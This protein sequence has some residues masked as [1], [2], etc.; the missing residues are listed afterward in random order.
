M[1][2]KAIQSDMPGADSISCDKHGA[3]L[4]MVL[5]HASRLYFEMLGSVDIWSN[6]GAECPE[7]IVDDPIAH[8]SNAPAWNDELE[9]WTE[10]P[11]T[12][13][14]LSLILKCQQNLRL[15]KILSNHHSSFGVPCLHVCCDS[16][17]CA[18]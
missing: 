5:S 18:G 15:A 8:R 10:S 3:S 11:K 16:M 9:N 6:A 4:A 7:V 12:L 17:H 1:T 2:P 13:I 14:S